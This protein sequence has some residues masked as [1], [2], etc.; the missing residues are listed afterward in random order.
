MEVVKH[1]TYG[2]WPKFPVARITDPPDPL[3]TDSVIHGSARAGGN[4]VISDD[5]DDML[6]GD[7]ER[8]DDHVRAR[9]TTMLIKMRNQGVKWPRVTTEL[10]DKA[11][12]TPDM[13]VHERADELLTFL[14][15]RS[16]TIGQWIPLTR[17]VG[18]EYTEE[19]VEAMARSESVS[20]SEVNFLL[21]E[22]ARTG[23]ILSRETGTGRLA[24]VTLLGREHIEALKNP[25]PA[26][27]PIRFRLP[28]NTEGSDGQSN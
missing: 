24:Q 4:Y 2:I 5:A 23:L 6:S 19:H 9:L 26:R 20:I 11:A 16:P 10:V 15:E 12:N 7:T 27:R 28:T 17:P 14:Q 3:S 22:L 18:R 13:P 25:Q 1:Q 21:D 8:F